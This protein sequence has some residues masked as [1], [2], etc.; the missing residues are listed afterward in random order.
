MNRIF[1][2]VVGWMG[3]RGLSA[4]SAERRVD[5]I[6]RHGHPFAERA[7]SLTGLCGRPLSAGVGKFAALAGL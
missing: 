5:R 4:G 2:H 1:G 6:V 3:P 7:G